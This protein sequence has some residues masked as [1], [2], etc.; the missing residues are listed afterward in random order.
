MDTHWYWKCN[1]HIWAKKQGKVC[2]FRFERATTWSWIFGKQYTPRTFQFD[3]QLD[4]RHQQTRPPSSARMSCGDL[5]TAANWAV[6]KPQDHA[7]WTGVCGWSIPSLHAV[8]Q[9]T[10]GHAAQSS[11][12]CSL[13]TA[14]FAAVPGSNRNP[15]ERWQGVKLVGVTSHNSAFF[16]PCRA[17]SDWSKST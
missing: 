11:W 9:Y 13:N 2:S 16:R 7:D 15:Y 4:L 6:F 3:T 1:L 10:T 8:I 14:R 17:I 12:P 5:G